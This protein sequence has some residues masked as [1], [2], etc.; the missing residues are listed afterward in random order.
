MNSTDDIR[1]AKSVLST[2]SEAML[3]TQ[4]RRFQDLLRKVWNE[5]TFYREYYMAHGI[6][7]RQ[8]AELKVGDL[9]FLTKRILMEN[10]DHAVTDSRLRITE[11][12]RWLDTVRDPRQLFRNEF[13]VV[14]SSGSSGTT[15]IF[16]YSLTDWRVMNSVMATRL[17]QPENQSR[18][19]TRVAF[20]R[21]A[22]GHFAGVATALHLPE[23]VYDRLIVSLLDP[24]AHVI[25]QLNN[26]RPHRLTG[27][28]SSIAMLAELATDGKL[29]V[30]PQRIFVSGDLLTKAIKQKIADA[31]GAPIT[32]LY[33]ASE[34]LFLA[35]ED[36]DDEEMSI[37]SDL[38]ILEILDE[39]NRSVK[40]GEDGR[41]VITNLYNHTLPILRYEL[42][43]YVIRGT[44]NSLEPSTIRAIRPGKAND[45]LPIVLDNGVP[46]TISPRAL[47]SFYAPGIDR[48]QFVL[49]Q[50]DR[51]RIDYVASW[52]IDNEVRNEFQRIL[53]LKGASRMNLEVRRVASIKPDPKTGKVRLVVSTGGQT[54]EGFAVTLSEKRS[55][56]GHLN[57]V[58]PNPGFVAF[59]KTEIEQSIPARF[60]QQAEKFSDRLAIRS[61]GLALT[62]DALNR[63]ANRIAQAILAQRGRGY[64]P[65]AL[66]LEQGVLAVVSILGILKA[67]K[68]YV[69]LDPSYPRAWLTAMLEDAQPS[70]IVTNRAN[71]GTA[72]NLV[73]QTGQIIDIDNLDSNF[74]DRSPGLSVL[75]G[76]FAYLFYTSGSTGQPKGV[77][78]THRNVLHQIATYTNALELSAN[79]RCTLL[80]SHGF[81]AS[82]L[83][84]FGALLNGAALLPFPTLNEGTAKLAAWLLEEE[85]T[86]LHWVPTGFRH[87]AEGLSETEQFPNIRA[88]VLGSEPVLSRDVVLY[89]KHF[90]PDCVLANRY[91]TTETGNIRFFFMGKDTNVENGFVPVGFALEDVDVVVVDETGQEVGHDRLG[92]IVVKSRYLSPGYWHATGAS[93]R[94]VPDDPTAPAVRTYRT[95]DVGYMRSDGCLFHLGR[96]DLQTKVRGH[97]IEI[98]QIEHALL[99]HPLVRATAVVVREN[100]SGEKELVAYLVVAGDTPPASTTLRHFLASR[101]PGYMVPGTFVLLENLPLT[102]TGKLNR[103]ALP[104]PADARLMPE[105]PFAEPRNP[106]EKKLADIW[107][108]VLGAARVGL[109]DSFFDL[110]GHSLIASTIV[111]RMGEVFKIEISLRQFFERS[112]IAQMADLIKHSLQINLE[113]AELANVLTEIESLSEEQVRKVLD[114]RS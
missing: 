31:W 32:N 75:P 87:L 15:G 64:E 3:Q 70:L 21:I 89:R 14:H 41:V 19:R 60:E 90:G 114:R 95:G 54:G 94:F 4:R 33:G 79:D 49:C 34:S 109:H 46:D 45:A 81:S 36:S 17:P 38:N 110:G 11:L 111:A 86:V 82:R 9:P 29:C 112:T 7:E 2:S 20:Y 71:R 76:C 77:P 44:T 10:F 78:Q 83:D 104:E 85:A 13:I 92:E 73:R 59:N 67:G 97:R 16:V 12:A 43:D 39:N 107:R 37:M 22:H 106:I 102:R 65:I 61:E 91:G 68:F 23:A 28:A 103:Q 25:E 98:G 47:T 69:P 48:A 74:S 113:G 40:P 62:Y 26:F 5:S 101:M 66:L 1:P 35:I 108:N 93:E 84:I 96:K 6:R 24:A 8:L 55:K 53:K 18:G 88:V 56:S 51:L 100:Q 30:Q 58:S 50:P 99:E 27:Y 72:I 52:N 105:A 57:R 80:H 63:A 42:G